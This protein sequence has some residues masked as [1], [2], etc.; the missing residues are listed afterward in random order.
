M[1]RSPKPISRS[2][3][4]DIEDAFGLIFQSRHIQVSEK[5]NEC[6]I[7]YIINKKTAVSIN[8]C[9][10]DC[11]ALVSNRFNGQKC[12]IVSETCKRTVP[13]RVVDQIARMLTE[14]TSIERKQNNA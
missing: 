9:Q 4:T 13:A 14:N 3:Q 1:T 12:K 6:G 11:L 8:W 10:D 5:K 7:E 2:D